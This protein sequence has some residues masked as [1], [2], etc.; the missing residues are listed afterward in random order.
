MENT[1]TEKLPRANAYFDAQNL[2]KS[3][4]EAWGVRYNEYD[5]VKLAHAIADRRGWALETVYFYT[6]TPTGGRRR[7][8]E[9]FWGNKLPALRKQGVQVFAPSL[10]YDNHSAECPACRG[11]EISC[12]RCG[13]LDSI[14]IPREKTVDVRIALDLV[15]H[16]QDQ[17]CDAAII[18][19]QDQDLQEA[20]REAKNITLRQERQVTFVSAFPMGVSNSKAITYCSREIF[21]RDV[22]EPCIDPDRY[23]WP[24]Y[25]D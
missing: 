16:A 2:F 5:P 4:K 17:L 6:G 24:E 9:R 10:K 7:N 15:L 22:Y 25:D 12:M 11:S 18:F 23:S 1:G 13:R 20:V 3:L 19:S 21:C 14:E 8:L